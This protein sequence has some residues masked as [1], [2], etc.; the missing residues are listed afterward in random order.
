ME[1]QALKA[2]ISPYDGAKWHPNSM[3]ARITL[4]NIFYSWLN[5]VKNSTFHD[6]AL[7]SSS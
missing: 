5:N 2:A 1:K 6:I 3:L 7:C 4:G